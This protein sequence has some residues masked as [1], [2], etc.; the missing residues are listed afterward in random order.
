MKKL[1]KLLRYLGLALLCGLTVALI[2]LLNFVFGTPEIAR[3]ELPSNLISHESVMGEQLL[4]ESKF[5][6]DYA[7]LK[8]NFVSQS[9]RA[10]CGVAS[11]VV[12]L[13]SLRRDQSTIT[14]ST[15]FNHKT[16]EVIHPLKVTFGGMTLAQLNGILQAH[17]LNTKL[18]YAA[19]INIAKFRSLAQKNL[20]N[21]NDI[22][23][24]NYR[25]PALNQ[26]GGGHISPIAAY[27]QQSDR[28][29]ILDVAAYK[30]PPTWVRLEDLW[31]GINSLDQTSNRSRGLIMVQS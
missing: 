17:Q 5:N 24:V 30:Y 13:N 19:D 15:I 23:L 9:R 26:P 18:V 31:N 25:R 11:S 2:I 14:Q 6:A 8:S 4:A 12:A 27:H 22:M 3:Q 7:L 20:S 16:R 1:R 21:P 10:F 29:L 28:V